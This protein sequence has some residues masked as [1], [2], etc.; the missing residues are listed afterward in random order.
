[1]S[2]G[3]RKDRVDGFARYKFFYTRRTGK[4]IDKQRQDLNINQVWV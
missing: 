1:M 4:V 2:Q 3:S